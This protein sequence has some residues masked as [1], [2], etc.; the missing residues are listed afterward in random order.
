[1]QVEPT[2]STGKG[3]DATI[4]DQR[5][6]LTARAR[7]LA[8]K[9]NISVPRT[10]DQFPFPIGLVAASIVDGMLI[11][12]WQDH[13]GPHATA[14]NIV[15]QGEMQDAF[16]RVHAENFLVGKANDASLQGFFNAATG[17]DFELKVEKLMKSGKLPLP[18]G[19]HSAQLLDFT[20]PGSDLSFLDK[21]GSVVGQAQIKCSISAQPILEHIKKYPGIDVIYA[22]HDA[23]VDA[24]KHHIQ[25]IGIHDHI[26]AVHGPIVVNVGV[27]ASAIHDHIADALHHGSYSLGQ[28]ALHHIPWISGTVI[29][30]RAWQRYKDGYDRQENMNKVKRDS[31]RAGIVLAVAEMLRERKVP[32]PTAIGVE[33]ASSLTTSAVFVV[34]D[35]WDRFASYE[36][37][38]LKRLQPVNEG[39]S[40]AK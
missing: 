15:G 6:N 31:I 12:S 17:S 19:V 22:S 24:A 3:L 14:E 39:M 10:E 13:I 27:K 34:R 36:S 29:G 40:I 16:R 18:Q 23:A 37:E 8:L 32:G 1:M 5:V 7:A 20:N 9:E 21:H 35:H 38:F 2:N 30:W 28:H 11:S 4:L 33:I 26:P 25:V